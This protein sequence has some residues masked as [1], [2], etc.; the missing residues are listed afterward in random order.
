MPA[1]LKIVEGWTDTLGPFTARADGVAVELPTDPDQV[2]LICHD[3]NG[4]AVELGGDLEVD[5][6]QTGNK[7]EWSY[8]P[9][10]EDFSNELQ[11]YTLRL[12]VT[13]DDGQVVFFSNSAADKLEVYKP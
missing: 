3:K 8:T 2:E 11:P 7:G 6:D 4:D 13:D 9:E 5:P 10:A 1:L 12:K